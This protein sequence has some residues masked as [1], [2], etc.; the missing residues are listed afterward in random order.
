[1]GEVVGAPQVQDKDAATKKRISDVV[2]RLNTLMPDLN[3]AYDEQADK[4]N[5]TTSEMDALTDA[6]LRRI[7]ETLKADML[8][9]MMEREKKLLGDLYEKQRDLTVI[10]ESR[11]KIEDALS[12]A[13]LTGLDDFD[14]RMAQSSKA[15]QEHNGWTKELTVEQAAAI[16]EL[17]GVLENEQRRIETYTDVNITNFSTATHAVD[18]LGVQIGLLEPVVDELTGI[19]GDMGQ[20]F[21]ENG[22]IFDEV[23][24]K[25]GI[26]GDKS[27]GVADQID[28]SSSKAA[29]ALGDSV[30]DMADDLDRLADEFDMSREEMEEHYDKLEKLA[31][32]N[33]NQMN[34][35][36][37]ERFD[38]EKGTKEQFLKMWEDEVIAFQTYETNLQIIASKVGP[39]VAAELRKLGPEAAPLIQ[40]FVDGT[41]EDMKRLATVVQNRTEAA[42]K[43]AAGELGLLGSEGEK[44]GKLLADGLIR[45]LDSK[46]Q[47]LINAGR[48]AGNA[49]SRGTKMSLEI[50]SPSK[51][52]DEIGQNYGGSIAGGVEKKERDVARSG[53]DIAAALV[54]ATRL[55]D[56]LIKAELAAASRVSATMI[57]AAYQMATLGAGSDNSRTFAPVINVQVPEGATEDFGRRVGQSIA[58]QLRV[59]AFQEGR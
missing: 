42:R 49:M 11:G 36:T 7:Y 59:L 1:M 18:D 53:S 33:K 48:T 3:L 31:E 58:D 12:K 10:Q 29:D 39:D 14:I 55:T 45:G 47:A 21:D 9:D 34:R 52:G 32:S 15:A 13:R 22:E 51:V 8:A 24:G 46:K 16:E 4:L 23:A 40:Q 5:K 30:D 20:R 35:F 44:G 19:A 28:E 26:L 6:T 50:A 57:P 41:D 25:L 17:N 43:A 27:E 54:E 56:P 37:K 2:E 38:Y